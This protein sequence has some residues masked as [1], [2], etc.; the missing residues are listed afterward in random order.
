MSFNENK[1]H[2]DLFRIQFGKARRIA[3]SAMP[4]RMLVLILAFVPCASP[5]LAQVKLRTLTGPK[6][7][8]SR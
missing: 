4:G 2:R 5:L 1:R 7:R 6:R 3:R 8:V